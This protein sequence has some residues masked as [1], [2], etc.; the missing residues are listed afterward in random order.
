VLVVVNTLPYFDIFKMKICDHNEYEFILRFKKKFF[1]NRHKISMKVI[2]ISLSFSSCY[3]I[4][5]CGNKLPRTKK[6]RCV[7]EYYF[8]RKNFVILFLCQSICPSIKQK[9]IRNSTLLK[10]FYM[11]NIKAYHEKCFKGEMK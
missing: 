2:T 5:T 11:T 10:Y 1:Y 3:F 4:F 6:K 8:P 7:V 9:K